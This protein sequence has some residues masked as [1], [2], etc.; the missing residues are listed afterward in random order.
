M[1]EWSETVELRDGAWALV[2][3][4]ND[5]IDRV[6]F[7]VSGLDTVEAPLFYLDAASACS[8]ASVLLKAASHVIQ[9][10]W[11]ETSAREAAL[12]EPFYD[13]DPALD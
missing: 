6:C 1:S 8:L 4:S 12:L 11:A 13:E 7:S 5:R 10:E 2:F 3:P 9:R